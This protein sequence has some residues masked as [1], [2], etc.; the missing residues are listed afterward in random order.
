MPD[1]KKQAFKVYCAQQGVTMHDV[2]NAL[3]DEVL[4]GKQDDLIERVKR[5]KQSL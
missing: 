2:I 1:D 5:R 4:E 3:V